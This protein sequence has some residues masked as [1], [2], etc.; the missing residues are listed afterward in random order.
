MSIEYQFSNLFACL[1]IFSLLSPTWWIQVFCSASFT[2]H[3]SWCIF[4]FC[5]C[6]SS[7]SYL[8]VICF[9][10]FLSLL[11]YHFIFSSL[12][13]ESI[14]C[15]IF[16]VITK[17]IYLQI[18]LLFSIVSYFSKSPSVPLCLSVSLFLSLSLYIYISLYIYTLLKI[19]HWA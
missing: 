4:Q 5:D 1:E 9:L 8:I 19:I 10:L 3:Y 6:V 12:V 15:L 7:V 13:S 14:F 18:S 16:I 17:L 2:I 11:L